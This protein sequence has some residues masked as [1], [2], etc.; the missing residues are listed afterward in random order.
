[1]LFARLETFARPLEKKGKRAVGFSTGARVLHT[2][3]C[4][5]YD[6]GARWKMPEPLPLSWDAFVAAVKDD[7]DR[8]A[9]LADEIR[10]L[11]AQISDPQVVAFAGKYLDKHQGN[12]DR[13]A[14]LVNRLALQI[15]KT[16]QEETP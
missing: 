5:A 1:V 3:P 9:A 6:A 12:A 11:V 4:A 15:D 7:G 8:T 14:E 2:Q 10:A 13:L 16:Q